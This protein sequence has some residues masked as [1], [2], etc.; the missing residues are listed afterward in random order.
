[1]KALVLSGGTGTRLRPLTYTSPKQLIPL[2]NKPIIIHVIEK[3]VQAGIHDIGIIVGDSQ[4]EIKK[5]V[6]DGGRWHAKIS[7]IYQ[8]L[9][10]GLAHAVKI[11]AP[12]IDGNDFL[13]IL[14]DNIFSMELSEFIGNFYLRRVN[15]SVLLH[16]VDK[17]AQFGVAVVENDRILKLVEKPKEFISDLILTGVYLFDKSIFAAIDQTVPSARGELEITDAIQNQLQQGGKITYDLIKG[18]W[19]DTGNEQ[20]IL[21]ANRRILDDM[22]NE[23]PEISDANSVLAGKLRIGKNVAISNSTIMGPAVIDEGSVITNSFVGPYTCIGKGVKI[24]NCE[25]E[26]CIILYGAQLDNVR[27]RI[28]NSLIGKNA[29]IKS[30]NKRPF[31]SA[32]VVADDS[33]IHL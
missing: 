15:T 14:G 33:K 16:Q 21:D 3:V 8:S 22:E 13:M 10:L 31:S 30:F 27:K 9:P 25:V 26:N 11:A 4:E 7:Y 20:D 12:F 28:S 1:M 18:W 23:M 24:Q 6:G 5:E 19:K 32:F 2:A 29:V 17:P